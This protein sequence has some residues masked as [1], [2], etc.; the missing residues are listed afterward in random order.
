MKETS[1]DAIEKVA[2]NDPFTTF[3]IYCQKNPGNVIEQQDIDEFKKSNATY[4]QT[5]F[6]GGATGGFVGFLIANRL[7]NFKGYKNWLLLGS[8][9][10]VG[11]KL[12]VGF[13]SFLPSVTEAK[14]KMNLLTIK[15]DDI[16][17]NT[18]KIREIIDQKEFEDFRE[19]ERR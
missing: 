11:M 13:S 15:Y 5:R 2:Q 4:R 8:A 18:G 19:N 14:N 7:S 17:R 1:T 9:Y 12:G 6:L 16:I 3:A 10:F